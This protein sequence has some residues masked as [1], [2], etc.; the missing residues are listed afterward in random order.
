MRGEGEGNPG[1]FPAVARGV[2]PFYFAFFLS[3]LSSLSFFFFSGG[4]SSGGCVLECVLK[5]SRNLQRK[6]FP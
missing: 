4:T 5:S 6:V 2:R 1:H 3:F